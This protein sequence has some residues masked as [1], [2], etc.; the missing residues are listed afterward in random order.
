MAEKAA[1]QTKTIVNR[2]SIFEVI[3]QENLSSTGYPALKKI[4]N[5][6]SYYINI[7][8]KLQLYFILLYIYNC[9][10]ILHLRTQND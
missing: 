3:A 8:K 4:C 10:S 6:S 5:V 7:I 9:F 2:P 1:H